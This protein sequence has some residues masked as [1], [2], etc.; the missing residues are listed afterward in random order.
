MIHQ[1]IIDYHGRIENIV[2]TDKEPEDEPEQVTKGQR[3]EASDAGRSKYDRGKV[4]L[5]GQA[6]SKEDVEAAEEEK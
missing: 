1:K 2:L 5:K 6:E 4:S 3:Q